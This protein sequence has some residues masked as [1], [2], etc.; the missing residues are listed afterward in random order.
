MNLSYHAQLNSNAPAL[1]LAVNY[2]QKKRDNEV[3][4]CGKSSSPQIRI[5]KGSEIDPINQILLLSTLHDHF[6]NSYF[7]QFSTI[8]ICHISKLTSCNFLP[9]KK[10]K[11]L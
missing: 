4:S 10:W 1:N 2:F 9:I 5:S 11:L 3:G 6:V 7:T 8:K